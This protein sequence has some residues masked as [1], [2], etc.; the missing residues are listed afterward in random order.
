MKGILIGNP[1]PTKTISHTADVVNHLNEVISG[2]A[3]QMKE[4]TAAGVLICHPRS[5][6]KQIMKNMSMVLRLKRIVNRPTKV[7]T[8]SL[9]I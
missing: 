5:L 3:E 6:F 9:Y 8:Y 7:D 1:L 2:A 4:F